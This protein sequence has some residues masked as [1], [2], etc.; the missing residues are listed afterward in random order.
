MNCQDVQKLLHGYVDDELDLTRSLEFEE[1][2]QECPA[3]AE[4]YA[5]LESLRTTIRSQARYYTPPAALEARLRSALDARSQGKSVFRSPRLTWLAVAAASVV[6]LLIAG[7]AFLSLWSA[8]TTAPGLTEQLLASH[9]RSQMLPGHLIDVK[10]SNQHTVKPW[11]N[12]KVG[13]SPEV[14]DLSGQDFV[15][16]GGRLDYIDRRPV[17]VVVYQRRK[18]KIDLY[19]WPSEQQNLDTPRELTRQGYHFL[20]W[21]R[22]GMTYWAVSDLNEKELGDF[23][24]LIQQR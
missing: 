5:E 16:L 3:C 22:G 18:H 14:A 24:R 11:F 4:V 7:W 23:M 2:F 9:I 20:S 12:D 1:H 19:I 10:S 17:A 8:R 21:E 15:L 6:L 13:F